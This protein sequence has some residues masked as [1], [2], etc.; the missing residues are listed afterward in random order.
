MTHTF[1][2][3]NESTLLTA[4]TSESHTIPILQEHPL[5]PILQYHC[6]LFVLCLFEKT[7]ESTF[8]A[9]TADCTRAQQISNIDITPPGC[10]MSK[11]LRP[12]EQQMLSI[13]FSDYALLS[14]LSLNRHLQPNVMHIPLFA[15]P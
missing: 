9:S 13:S 12:T 6:F 11:H 10:V 8:V 4:E 1:A 3:S 2:E 5:A 7:T 15:L 14:H